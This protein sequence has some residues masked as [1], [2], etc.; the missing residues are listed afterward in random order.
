[1][2]LNRRITSGILWVIGLLTIVTAIWVIAD[3]Y[4]T[5]TCREIQINIDA[6]SNNKFIT[7]QDIRNNLVLVKDSLI[8]GK[9]STINIERMESFINNIPFVLSSKV[10]ISLTGILKINIKQRIPIVRIQ[11]VLDQSYYVS[12]DGHLLP[13]INGKT[14]RVL[15]ANGF[16]QSSFSNDLK[17]NLD[18]KK[19]KEDSMSPNKDLV[20]IFKAANYIFHDPFWQAQIQQLYFEKNG[21]ILMMPLVGDHIINLGETNDISDKLKKLSVFYKKSKFLAFWD[22]YDTININFNGQI[23]CSKKTMLK[24]N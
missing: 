23:V 18:L 15:F 13:I 3:K 10:Y 7:E 2:I 14:A 8:G 11:N 19:A 9:I 4:K 1:M 21:N 6:P 17:L 16:I 24:N 20:K 5:N 22:K 12:E